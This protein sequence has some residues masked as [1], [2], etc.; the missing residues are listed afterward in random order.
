MTLVDR[1]FERI[2]Y[3]GPQTATLE[4][5]NGVVHAHVRSIPFENLEPAFGRPVDL[6]LA[7]VEKK[8]IDRRRG[9]YC[10][11][12]NSLFHAVL[13]EL[14]FHVRGIGARVR[15]GRPRDQMPA[16]THFF[17]L[18]MLDG[19]EWIVDVGVGGI[20]PTAA[21]RLHTDEEQPTPHEPRRVVRSST[22]FLHQ[23]RLADGW[24]DVCEFT[25]DEMHPIDRELANWYTSTHPQS[26]FRNNVIA[27][28]ALADGGRLN[29][30]NR[31]L[32]RRRRDGSSRVRT[33]ASPS[34]LLETLEQEFG[35][36]LESG[37]PLECAGLV[38]D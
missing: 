28:R 18:V 35:L 29:L 2:G 13:A 1:Y 38:W 5:L 26:Y 6:S 31:E 22:A 21:F 20:S 16:R 30:L 7:A 11:E 8:L 25:L 32:T 23:V 12:Q 4:A 9:G 3:T 24:Q 34:D 10:F 19:E 33:I 15:F 17:G 36:K 27:A 37:S 14:G